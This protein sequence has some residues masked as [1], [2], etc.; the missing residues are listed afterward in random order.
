MTSDRRISLRRVFSSCGR[1]AQEAVINCHRDFQSEAHT[2]GINNS[3]GNT[4][5]GG[6]CN[7]GE[8]WLDLAWDE[9]IFD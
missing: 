5:G 8:C 4:S 7:C 1:A 3:C 6:Y 2:G 9:N